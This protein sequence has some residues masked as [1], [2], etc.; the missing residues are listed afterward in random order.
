MPT[1]EE[2]ARFSSSSLSSGKEKESV[3]ELFRDR[4]KTSWSTQ[5]HFETF[6]RGQFGDV[7]LLLPPRF[8][9]QALIC[10]LHCCKNDVYKRLRER[11]G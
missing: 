9:S 8:L 4:K 6:V 5:E 3:L 10:N 1:R 11:K 2:I 7:L